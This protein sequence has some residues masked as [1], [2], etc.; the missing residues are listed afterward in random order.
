[1]RG[2]ERIG[3]P[4]T[5][6]DDSNAAPLKPSESD[7]AMSTLKDEELASVRLPSFADRLRIIGESSLKNVRWFPFTYEVIIMQWAA[8]LAQQDKRLAKPKSFLAVASARAVGVAV[9][10]APM[11]FE[12]IKQSMGFRLSNFHRFLQKENLADSPPLLI[13]EDAMVSNL[14]QVIARVSDG[15]LDHHNFD[16]PDLRQMSADVNNSIALFLRDL[17][18]YMSPPSVYK[19]ILVYFN[20]FRDSNK[21][22]GVDRE[23]QLGQ[24]VS[25]EILRLQLNAITVFVRYADFIKINGPQMLNWKS[26]WTSPPS[27]SKSS[28][29][30]DILEKYENF[31]WFHEDSG[32]KFSPMMQPHWLSEAVIEICLVGIEH[33]DPAIQQRSSSILFELFWSCSQDSI[34]AGI[35]APA[36]SM[37]VPFIEKMLVRSQYIANFQPKCQLRKDLLTSFIYILQSSPPNL[38]R[39]LWRRLCYRLEDKSE[40]GVEQS[41]YT[42]N[43]DAQPKADVI[44]MFST[45]NLCLRTIEYEGSDSTVDNESPLETKENLDLWRREYLPAKPSVTDSQTSSSECSA[46]EE[47]CYTSS[48]SRQWQ[49]HDGSTVVIKTTNQIVREMYGLLNRVPEGKA[50]LNPAI[51]NNRIRDHSFLTASQRPVNGSSTKF[52]RSDIVM[53]VRAASSVYLHALALRQSDVVLDQTFVFSE[54]LIKIFG[55]K[56][57]LEAVGETLQHWMRVVSLQCGA[58]RALV[59]IA[60]T[61]LLELML[62]SSWECFGSFF[63]IRVPLLAV[64]TEVMERIVATAAAR[65]YKEQR[66]KGSNFEDFS[67]IGAEASLVP[68]WKTLDRIENNPA[69]QNIA[70]RGALIRMAGKLKVRSVEDLG[71]WAHAV[72]LEIISCLCCS[73]GSLVYTIWSKRRYR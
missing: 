62:R 14:E 30:D 17:F 2:E 12:V 71:L 16:S 46:K 43:A 69:S 64:Q 9:A 44:D 60:A 10:S 53:F 40:N 58:R 8:I 25:W 18:S 55:I 66:Q 1:M 65:Y 29:F 49:A 42:S 70:F 48:E 27:R 28:F 31:R 50:L 7:D 56:L 73:K 32:N 5:P 54:E 11:L 57:F 63:R 6:V 21:T 3:S 37:F 35:S 4:T 68:L 26:W 67:N 23:S 24:R 38:L 36:A 39:A 15:C 61:D 13:L 22:I 45:L 41:D 51:Q 72:F 34:L 47:N 19:L 20:R 59:R 33:A 52:N